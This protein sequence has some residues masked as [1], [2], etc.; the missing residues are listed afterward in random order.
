MNLS[1]RFIESTKEIRGLAEAFMAGLNFV[2]LANNSYFYKS[3]EIV[4]WTGFQFRTEGIYGEVWFLDLSEVP[5]EL[6]CKIV[7]DLYVQ[8]Q[9]EKPV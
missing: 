9:G 5:T 4:A 6:L 8:I 1:E 3:R 7:D 2:E